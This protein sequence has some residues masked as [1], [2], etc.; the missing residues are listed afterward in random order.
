[1]AFSDFPPKVGEGVKY[2]SKQEYYE[3]LVDYTSHFNLMPYLKLKTKVKQAKL[4][5][6]A[7]KWTVQF[8]SPASN[9]DEEAKFDYLIVATGAN[10]TPNVPQSITDLKQSTG[11]KGEIMHSAQYHSSSQVKGK[12]VL[13][14]GTGESAA[15]VAA[16]ATDTAK[17][18]HVWGRRC[19]DMAPRYISDFINSSNYDERKNLQDQ[20]THDKSN[21]N[22]ETKKKKLLPKDCLEVVT[23]SR[24]VKNLPLGVW[25]VAL[26]GLGNDVLSK[27]GSQSG[28]GIAAKLFLKAW[29][30]D[31][32]S[33]DTS[34]VT[35]KSQ[36]IPIAASQGKLDI[37][38]APSIDVC[39]CEDNDDATQTIR[40]QNPE[41][42]GTN[43]IEEEEGRKDFIELD[44]DVIVCCTGYQLDFNWLHIENDDSNLGKVEGVNTNINP[45]TWYKHCFP[46]QQHGNL[47]SK[48]AFLGFARPHSGGIPA[49]SEIL[50]RY[51]GQILI[52]NKQLPLSYTEL[53]LIEGNHEAELYHQSPHQTMVVDYVAFMTSVA[54]LVGCTPQLPAMDYD[55]IV[56]YWTFP[57][58][59]CFFRSGGGGRSSNVGCNIAAC[60]NVLDRFGTHD[61][62]A[63]QPLLTIELI[64]TIIMPFI[65]I[66][67]YCMDRIYTMLLC[68]L[69]CYKTYPRHHLPMLYRWRMSKGHFLYTNS[70]L[71][72][73]DLLF[74]PSQVIVGGLGLLMYAIATTALNVIRSG[75]NIVV[76][77]YLSM[78]SSA[79]SRPS[80]VRIGTKTRRNSNLKMM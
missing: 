8:A 19:P 1:M 36:L 11:F 5:R 21:T 53:A 23:T 26:H 44:F 68:L 69:S 42:Y 14:V 41:F 67:S 60:Q 7:Q 45:R 20:H 22:S 38:I 65:N 78:H 64:F 52:G 59:P 31:Y 16:S 47:R 73:N 25:S 10:H 18:V 15:D 80:P 35:T 51:I 48:L 63:P 79:D 49:C 37:I 75:I 9:T 56:K 28:Q 72:L 2:W 76:D 62:L 4:D 71:S 61:V 57:L 13:V 40:F 39:A 3:Y 24:I 66:L 27:H 54:E 30:N 74:V 46:T 6:V 70:H 29:S 43:F 33:S 17:S 55:S 58:W 12:R 32:F 77:T 50:A 34:L